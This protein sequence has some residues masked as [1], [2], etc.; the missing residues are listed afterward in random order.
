MS[1]TITLIIYYSAANDRRPAVVFK[2]PFYFSC[3]KTRGDPHF[4][5]STAVSNFQDHLIIL[6]IRLS[7]W[8]QYKQWSSQM[9]WSLA[10]RPGR[11]Q[12]SRSPVRSLDSAQQLLRWG[13]ASPSEM[14]ESQVAAWRKERML[15]EQKIIMLVV[16]RGEECKLT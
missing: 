6:T 7:L 11:P 3:G 12:G 10:R 5:S 2:I 9:S 15:P 13:L 16:F 8:P 1:W 14:A 4:G